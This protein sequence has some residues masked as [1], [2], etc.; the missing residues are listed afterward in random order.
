[1]LEGKSCGVTV[2]SNGDTVV[3][4]GSSTIAHWTSLAADLAPIPV[5]RRGISGARLNQI[6]ALMPALLASY[7]PRAVI[8]YAGEN[9]VAGFLGSKAKSPEQVRDSFQVFCRETHRR[10]PTTP[11][12]FLSIKPGKTRSAHASAFDATNKLIA[13]TCAD[14]DRL[15]FVDATT[16]LLAADGTVRADVYERD[17]IHLSGEGYRI[18]RTS[19]GASSADVRR[20]GVSGRSR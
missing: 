12:Y 13:E 8:L 5:T 3:F 20:L 11:I 16:P 9:D 7:Q 6:A 19:F 2:S 17:G 14:D 10:L 15:H 4:T 1:M 18:L